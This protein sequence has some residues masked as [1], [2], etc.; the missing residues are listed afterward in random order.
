VQY[1]N[2]S[3][4][5]QLGLNLE[6]MAATMVKVPPSGWPR[7]RETWRS[8]RQAGSPERPL[9]IS[10]P[11]SGFDV[12]RFT[13]E[14]ME[15][16]WNRRDYTTISSSYAPA[17]TFRGATD[18]AFS[19][20]NDY[21]AMLVDLGTA[22]PDLEHQVDEV[23]WMGNEKDGFLTSERW[24]ATGTHAGAGVYGEPT[25]REVEIW[26]IT[27]HKIVNGKIV[28]EWMLFN[29]LDLLMQIAAAR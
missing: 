22:F 19:G 16:L 26:G 7:D 6:E 12:D 24:S 2:S 18:R 21:V 29:E 4:I 27:Q 15:M 25:G 11:V 20:A 3:L 5:L 1:N 17:F 9:S 23:Y 10:A 28:A 13:R 14:T 8:L